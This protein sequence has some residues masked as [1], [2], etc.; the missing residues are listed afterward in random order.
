MEKQRVILDDLPKKHL[1]AV[2]EGY[3]DELPQR[4]QA[5][6]A[7]PAPRP[8][9]TMSWNWQRTVASLASVGLVVLLIFESMPRKQGALGTDVLST[10]EN[11]AIVDYLHNQNLTPFDLQDQ[12]DKAAVLPSGAA[13]GVQQLNVS[14]HDI[15]EHLENQKVDEV[16]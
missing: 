7:K 2:P 1:F 5:R 14:E 6:V 3:F 4:V 16:L 15:L 9:F 10:V 12:L 11:E 8:A 13:V